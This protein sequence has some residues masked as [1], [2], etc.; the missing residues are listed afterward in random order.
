MTIRSESV[1][2]F[3]AVVVI[4]LQSKVRKKKKNTELVFWSSIKYKKPLG[5]MID[6]M[7]MFVCTTENDHGTI[8]ILSHKY[9]WSLMLCSSPTRRK[10]ELCNFFST[11]VQIWR[12]YFES[13]I[14]K[15]RTLTFMC[16]HSNKNTHKQK[17]QKHCLP[18]TFDEFYNIFKDVSDGKFNIY[19]RLGGIF[20][21]TLLGCALN[22]H[23]TQPQPHYSQ[24][25]L[26]FLCASSVQHD[27]VCCGLIFRV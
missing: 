23:Y 26:P 27:S 6:I 8:I 16:T 3:Y 4:S 18:H 11:A 14:Y 9:A 24:S 17:L 13:I 7:L 25:L 1:A 15:T 12:T 5:W 20:W 21:T 10:Q 2:S 22:M 19:N